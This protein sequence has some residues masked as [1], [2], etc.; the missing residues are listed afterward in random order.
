[1][2]DMP[3]LTL[4]THGVPVYRS[5]DF[6]VVNG[7]NEGDPISFAD[8]MVLDDVYTLDPTAQTRDIG[9]HRGQDGSYKVSQNSAVGRIGAEVHLDCTVTLMSDTTEV[10]D[11]L[12]LVEVDRAGHV[13]EVYAMPLV[14]LHA[15]VDYRLVGIDRNGAAQKL[16]QVACVSFTRGTGITLGSGRQCPVED[17][18][19]GDPVLTRDNGVQ[20]LRWIGQT[21]QRAVGA[22]APIRIAAGTL[23]NT[24]DLIVSPDHRLFV[25]QRVDKLG[26]GRAEL[27]VRASHLVNGTSVTV[28]KGGF[29]DYFQL[30]FDTHQIIYAEGIAAESM[31]VDA[32]TAQLLE[33]T[34]RGTI[35][36]AFNPQNS[37]NALAVEKDLLDRPDA[38]DILRRA[39]KG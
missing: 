28:Q 25:Y 31:L 37:L 26:A 36:P 15:K 6:F 18:R 23:N 21:T 29:V 13:Q 35:A 34:T 14:P 39:S 3:K 16:A 4:E 7:A 12:L 27:L 11:V 24:N 2:A 19:P 30:L 17:L 9:L 22:F 38:V 33:E 5:G 10:T 8:D 32:S 1:M 20:P